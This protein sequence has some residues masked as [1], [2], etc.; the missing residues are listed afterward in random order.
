MCSL[1]Q[2]QLHTPVGTTDVE[3]ID[4]VLVD[5]EQLEFKLQTARYF[6]CSSSIFWWP[7]RLLAS[8]VG[9]HAQQEQ[10]INGH[11]CS[12]SSN[13]GKHVQQQLINS[14]QWSPHSQEK[15]GI[16]EMGEKDTQLADPTEGIEL[17][18]EVGARSLFSVGEN[19]RLERPLDQTDKGGGFLIPDMPAMGASMGMGDSILVGSVV[20]G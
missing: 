20:D 18:I 6:A 5:M 10:V 11:P 12:Q 19:A 7:A 9:K 13:E 8:F 14:N 3:L 1:E 15:T 16:L 2:E 4:R 17:Q